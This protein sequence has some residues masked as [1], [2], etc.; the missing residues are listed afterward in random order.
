MSL[1]KC[2]GWIVYIWYSSHNDQA[3]QSTIC[4]LDLQAYGILH[5]CINMLHTLHRQIKI[6]IYIYIKRDIYVKKRHL[7]ISATAVM[8][9]AVIMM[10]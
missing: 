2:S 8:Q 7:H 1:N 4:M 5:I 10:A 9:P 3:I 6:L